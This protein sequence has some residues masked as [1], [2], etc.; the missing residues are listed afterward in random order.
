MKDRMKRKIAARDRKALIRRTLLHVALCALT[1][2]LLAVGALLTMDLLGAKREAAAFE[3]LRVLHKVAADDRVD[4]AQERR[5]SASDAEKTAA[6]LPE[7]LTLHE[8]NKDFAGWIS[9]RDTAIDYPVMY[10]PEKPEY[11]LHRAFDASE[12]A[13]G[14]PFVGGE[15]SLNPRSANVV[16]CGHHMKD[17]T[18]FK[19]LIGYEREDFCRAHPTIQFDTLFE[20]GRYEVIAA[21][22]TRPV[23]AGGFAF[24]QSVTEENLMEYVKAV[25]RLAFY[26][27]AIDVKAQDALLTLVTC[28]YQ[29]E[30]GRLVVV[31]RRLV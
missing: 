26:D 10:T 4:G 25:K 1:I 27:T 20:R 17:G 23:S 16:I 28:D 30:N 18:M 29:A 13:S 22:R 24:H 11:Y 19:P 8:Q 2:M 7:Y 15:S 3:E 6:V 14:T 31:A 5:A 9:I 12:S 21:F